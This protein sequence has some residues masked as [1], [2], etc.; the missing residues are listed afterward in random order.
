MRSLSAGVLLTALVQQALTSK[1]DA[2]LLALSA[3]D[4][5]GKKRTDL[6][7]IAGRLLSSARQRAKKRGTVVE[8]TAHNVVELLRPGV[9]SVTGIPWQ[10]EGFLRHDPWAPSLDRIDS[11]RGYVHGNVRVVVWAYNQAK[12][13]WPEEVFHELA[14][15]YVR[16]LK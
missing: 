11:E 7:R 12:S 3:S 8:L 5:T 1:L 16:N 2:R 15:A 14:T 9:C 10:A 13:D 6:W 4:E